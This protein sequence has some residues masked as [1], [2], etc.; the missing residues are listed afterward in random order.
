MT[1]SIL[2]KPVNEPINNG[3]NQILNINWTLKTISSA[4]VV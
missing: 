4:T 3:N 2:I 1:L